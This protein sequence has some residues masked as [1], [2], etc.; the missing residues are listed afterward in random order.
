MIKKMVLSEEVLTALKGMCDVI[1]DKYYLLDGVLELNSGTNEVTFLDGEDLPEEVV[2]FLFKEL[3]ENGDISFMPG[4][5][6][7]GSSYL[8]EA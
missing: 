7:Q 3:M 5:N 6:I 1:D 2:S 8:H 4:D